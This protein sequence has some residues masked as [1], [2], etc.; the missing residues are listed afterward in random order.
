MCIRDRSLCKDSVVCAE[1]KRRFGCKQALGGHMSKAHPGKS[2]TY[3]K[4]KQLAS[5][6]ILERTRFLMAKKRFYR[7]LSCDYEKLAKSETGKEKL[8]KLLKRSRI[9]AIKKEISDEEVAEYLKLSKSTDNL[10]TNSY[11]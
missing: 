7:E 6:R 4:K 3:R 2:E 8:K 1:C 10:S 11:H 9:R 5:D